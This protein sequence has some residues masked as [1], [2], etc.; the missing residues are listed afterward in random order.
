VTTKVVY[1]AYKS[2]KNAKVLV[3]LVDGSVV[4]ENYGI[5]TLVKP[6]ETAKVIDPA[7]VLQTAVFVQ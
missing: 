2:D 6:V 7:T 1:P 5:A 4:S 3:G